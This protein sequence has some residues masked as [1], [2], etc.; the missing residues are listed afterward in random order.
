[1]T[2]I[3]TNFDKLPKS[4]LFSKIGEKVAALRAKDPSAQILN[5]GVGDIALPLASSVGVALNEAAKEMSSEVYGY[6]PAEG[7][8]FLR[9][10]ILET[11]YAGLGITSSDIFVSEGIVRDI[12]DIQ[13]LF[14]PD[15]TVGIIDPTYPA[16]FQSSVLAGKNPH[17]IPCL[18]ENGFIPLPPNQRLDFV[19]LCTPNNPT[20]V[21]MTKKDLQLWI[22]W[23]IENK[24]V[25]LIDAAYE[26]FI[27]SGDVPQTIFELPGAK[28]VA[29][30]FRSFSKSAGF[31]AL[32]L[33]YTVIP[34]KK[35]NQLWR[36]RQDIKTNGISYPIQKAGYASLFGAG[37]AEC[38]AQVSLYSRHAKKLKEALESVGYTCYG[39][40]DSPY[41]WWKISEP[42]SWKF[43]DY[44]LEKL[45]LITIPGR[46]FGETGEGF[47]RL[48]S[49]I[50]EKTLYETVQRLQTCVMK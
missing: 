38:E 39:G 28:D 1:M 42:D 18:E 14:P 36:Q 16:Y 30:E 15:A 19:Y 44:L 45:H 23:A 4:Y 32:R 49:F 33:G 9:Q 37:K 34:N 17:L 29:I 25:L 3:N 40:L 21:A 48:S 31:T 50:T 47:I 20:G 2:V 5:L 13:D 7:H 10:K 6:G 41:V 11:A 8:L 26:K 43:F 35:L 24:S 27:T 46:G 12:C 22:D